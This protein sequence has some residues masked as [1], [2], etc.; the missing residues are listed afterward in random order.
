MSGTSKRRR[1]ALLAWA[2]SVCQEWWSPQRAA[3]AYNVAPYGRKTAISATIP[4]TVAAPSIPAGTKTA[5][6]IPS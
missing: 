6:R 1:R 4:A 2:R 5:K 3:A